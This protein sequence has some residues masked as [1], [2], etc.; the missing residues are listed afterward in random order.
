YDSDRSVQRRDTGRRLVGLVMHYT[1]HTDNSDL[2]LQEAKELM[3]GYG[4]EA[5]SLN[6]N[7]YD[8]AQAYLFFRWSLHEDVVASAQGDDIHSPHLLERM[9][10][11]W[12][13]LLLALIEGYTESESTATA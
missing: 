13:E 8:T 2:Y 6:M 10:H 7:L 4:L 11:F 5:K 3:R 1:S 12:D 9:N